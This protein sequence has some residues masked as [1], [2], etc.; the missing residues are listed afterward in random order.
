[1]QGQEIRMKPI[2]VAK[3]KVISLAL[4]KLQI[5]GINL[6]VQIRGQQA[7]HRLPRLHILGQHGMEL[8]KTKIGLTAMWSM[9]MAG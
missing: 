3:E 4:R 1:M 8:T 2:E 7:K 6:Q 9:M 5:H